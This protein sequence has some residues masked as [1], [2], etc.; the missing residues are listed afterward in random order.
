MLLGAADRQHEL[1]HTYGSHA[2]CFMAGGIIVSVLA[3]HREVYTLVL[4]QTNRGCHCNPSIHGFAGV[5]AMVCFLVVVAVFVVVGGRCGRC[6]WL[7]TD[8]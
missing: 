5:T 8:H 1:C 2:V 6:G 7:T 3:P 4:C